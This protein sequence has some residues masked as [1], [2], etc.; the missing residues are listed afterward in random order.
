MDNDDKVIW[1]ASI[2]WFQLGHFWYCKHSIILERN[3]SQKFFWIIQI[4]MYVGGKKNHLWDKTYITRDSEPH[5][6]P[7]V[8]V[9][10]LS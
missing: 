4:N 3:I 7:Q 1:D 9:P 6:T 10:I 5:V 2:N 8:F